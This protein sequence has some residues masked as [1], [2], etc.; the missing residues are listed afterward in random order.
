MMGF[1]IAASARLNAAALMSHSSIPRTTGWTLD[2]PPTLPRV[3]MQS[4]VTVNTC[5][6]GSLPQSGWPWRWRTDDVR[7]T[8]YDVRCCS[9]EDDDHLVNVPELGSYN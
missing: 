8:M 7:C 4:G 6:R 3:E 9:M 2:Y 5:H 1:A